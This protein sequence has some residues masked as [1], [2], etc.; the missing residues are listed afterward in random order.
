MKVAVVGAGISGLTAAYLLNRDGHQVRLFEQETRIGGHTRTLTVEGPSG[1]IPVD[2]GFIVYN[3]HTYPLFTGLLRE[4]GVATQPSD[5][6][7]SSVCRACGTQF[8]S[9]GVAGVFASPA[10]VVRPSH[11][12]MVR[13]V[14]RFYDDA[15]RTMA[16]GSASELT[17][18]EYL[19]DRRFGTAFRN[20]FIIPVTS[21]VWSTGIRS[22]L[23]FPADYLLRFLD[24]HG[25]IGYPSTVRWRT[26][27]GGSHQ[28][29]RRITDTLPDDAVRSGSAVASVTRSAAGVTVVTE[30]AACEAFDAIVMATHAD[31]ALRL[32]RDADARER[33]ALAG[34]DYT[35]NEVVLHTDERLLPRR[36]RARASW[37]VETDDCRRPVDSLT[38]TYHMNRLQGLPGPI[39]YA[40]S[41]NPGNRIRPEHVISSVTMSHPQYTFRTLHAQGALRAVQGH[42]NTFYAGAHLGYGFHED[43]CRS[44]YEAAEAVTSAAREQAA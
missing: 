30:D 1:A 18:G 27:Q 15:R 24:N 44:G 3:E 9:R 32:L 17:L 12:S 8:S 22:V 19:D 43:G 40:V 36:A 35:D 33:G 38:M 41:V 14:F 28:Y 39:Q 34:F 10:S 29:V 6:S 37:N 42:R 7:F 11:W 13:D 25:L 21:A 31:T 23:D 20:H 16:T 5:M 4:L 26:I 2:T